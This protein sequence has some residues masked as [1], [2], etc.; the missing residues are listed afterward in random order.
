MKN[1][2]K[3][4]PMVCLALILIAGLGLSAQT[5]QAAL[6]GKQLVVGTASVNNTGDETARTVNLNITL[7][8]GFNDV[9]GLA[10]TLVY[11]KAV[12]D[13]VGLVQVTTPIDGRSVIDPPPS[14]ATVGST[15]YYQANNK[16]DIGKAMIA[17]AGANF[18]ATGTADVVPFM[19]RFRVKPGAG[20]GIFPINVQQTIIGPDTAANA[21]YTVPTPIPVATGLAP[22]ADPTTAAS[23]AVQLVPGSITVSGGYNVSGTV[24][25]A[26]A[27]PANGATVRLMKM[28]G[29]IFVVNEEKTVSSGGFTFTN[30]PNGIYKVIVLANNPG[31]Q[32]RYE[33]SEFTVPSTTILSGNVDIGTITLLAYSPITG[34]ITVNGAAIPGVKAKVMNGTTLIGYFA[35]D[36]NGNFV[37]IPL[38]PPLGN[39]TV[40]AVYGS[41]QVAVVFTGGVFNWTLP[42][43]TLSG[44][45]S[46]L[47]SEQN[48]MVH[49]VSQTAQLEKTL[50][51]K[52]AGVGNDVSYQFDNL[53]P[54]DDYIVSVVGDGIPVTYY[55]GV[56]DIANATAR[57]VTASQDTSGVNFSFTA[58]TVNI[59]GKITE[60]VPSAGV[61]DVPVFALETTTFG[62]QST[63]SNQSGDYTLKLAAG[64]YVVFAY[65]DNGKTFYYKS[66][67]ETTQVDTEA[68]PVT[69][70]VTPGASGINI[71]LDEAICS[72]NG[73]VTYR[74]KGGDPVEGIMVMAEGL[75]G[76][77]IDVTDASGNYV[78][79][80]LA[81]GDTYAYDVTIYPDQPY[82]PQS[83]SAAS[84]EQGTTLN[85]VIQTGWTL[86]GTVTE[87][88]TPTT[89]IMGAWVYLLD[90]SGVIQGVPAISDS[91]GLFTL[92]DIP[93]GVYTLMAEHPDYQPTEEANLTVEQDIASRS[94]TMTKGVS[95]AGTVTDTA[96]PPIPISG[97]LVIATA[98]GE[99][100]RYGIT[101]SDGKYN[102]SGLVDAKQYFLIFTKPLY[103]K[104]V[105]YPVTAPQAAYDVTLQTPAAK[106][107]LSGTVQLSGG[108][109]ISGAYVVVS[110]ASNKF[111]AATTTGTGGAFSFTDLVASDDYRIVVIPGGNKPVYIEEP[112][113]LNADVTNKVITIPVGNI[114][115]TVHLSDSA[116]GAAV[117]VY[118]LD[119][120]TGDYVTDVLAGDSGGGNYAYTFNGVDGTKTFKVVAFSTGYTLGWYATGATSLTEATAVQ[121]GNPA[122]VDFTM[123]K[124]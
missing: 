24:N 105:R 113:N 38:E 62:I 97:V 55:A 57:S 28:A 42:L 111:Y 117:T 79:A 116:T 18:F 73:Q 64:T 110:S 63:Y 23:F 58:P 51:K 92:A 70:T 103:L 100:A 4:F 46:G 71:Q 78:L 108:G 40:T 34:K 85:F 114:S 9:N 93:N 88:G 107:D 54:A 16:A 45:I 102:L 43:G 106:W 67:T 59:A 122:L 83:K 75:K 72:I 101:G 5:A 48:V 14:A 89:K 69:V 29:S 76:S 96:V 65:K 44:T 66:L 124:P 35:T 95:I 74:R 26:P 61:P 30:K 123:T 20:S 32:T 17:A 53:L 41:E 27:T 52:G 12:F 33:G 31:F 36:A 90:S 115:G 99:D 21:G 121:V 6:P 104:Q 8:G 91:N 50:S 77:A 15:I 11:D 86:S 22:A 120:T 2:I 118:L 13:F 7:T 49:I 94:V 82:P 37:T 60:G 119:A 109:G 10:F 3:R 25:Y 1:I 47:E 56:T 87:Q 81:C 84:S 98:V 19:A 80:G 68:T 112:F 39:Y